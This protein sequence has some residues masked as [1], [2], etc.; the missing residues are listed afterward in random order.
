MSLFKIVPPTV[1]SVDTDADIEDVFSRMG[2][3]LD[4]SNDV[5][6]FSPDELICTGLMLRLPHV[7]LAARLSNQKEED[8]WIRAWG[9]VG[10]HLWS[11]LPPPKVSEEMIEGPSSG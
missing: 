9:K 2:D 5:F 10:G 8:R 11:V 3:Y 7:R 1:D 6:R 4:I